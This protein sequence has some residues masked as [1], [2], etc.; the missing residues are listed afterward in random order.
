MPVTPHI[1]VAAGHGHT[2]PGAVN[3]RLG[4]TERDLMRQF[5]DKVSARLRE[6]GCRVSNDVDYVATKGTYNRLRKGEPAGLDMVVDL[7]LNAFDGKADGDTEGIRVLHADDAWDATKALAQSVADAHAKAVGQSAASAR[8][9]RDAAGTYVR[10][11]MLHARPEC[12]NLLL[13]CEFIDEDHYIWRWINN[14]D[15]AARAVADHLA[16]HYGF[17]HTPA[18]SK[19]SSKT[20]DDEASAS[21][22]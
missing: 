15:A 10:L 4:I 8:A 5:R 18:K 22:S 12:T 21:D 3:K 16:S 13:E 14:M 1:F 6:L 2:D 19:R 11:M 20:T 9:K 7:H 17:T